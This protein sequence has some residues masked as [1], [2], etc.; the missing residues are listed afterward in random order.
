MYRVNRS[1]VSA[2]LSLLISEYLCVCAFVERQ[3][4]AVN[5]RSRPNRDGLQKIDR[6]QMW[7]EAPNANTPVSVL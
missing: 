3:F 5:V 1:K 2:P 7:R 6:H 4:E